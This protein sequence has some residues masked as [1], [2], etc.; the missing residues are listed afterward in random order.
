[1]NIDG[2]ISRLES[3]AD[4]VPSASSFTELRSLGSQAQGT[5][6]AIKR[7]FEERGIS[8]ENASLLR[9]IERYDRGSDLQEISENLQIALQTAAG[10]FRSL[11]E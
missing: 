8:I 5:M 9:D 2:M 1:M 10:Y 3:I 11:A 4:A 6:L 7:A